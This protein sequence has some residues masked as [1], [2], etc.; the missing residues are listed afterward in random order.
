MPPS[1]SL[2]FTSFYLLLCRI[3]ALGKSIRKS[4]H[5][6]LDRAFVS[7]K[8]DIST[9]NLDV[10]CIALLLVIFPAERSETPVLGN[11][12]LLAAG[13]FI[14]GSTEGLDGGCTI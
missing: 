2:T 10:A 14:L 4:C 13:E 8:L 9:V 7:Q 11:D 1:S 5:V 6:P 12:D 3:F